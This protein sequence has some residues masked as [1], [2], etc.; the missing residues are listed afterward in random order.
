MSQFYIKMH[1]KLLESHLLNQWRFLHKELQTQGNNMKNIFSNHFRITSIGIFVILLLFF[2]SQRA[3][4]Q[5]QNMAFMHGADDNSGAGTGVSIWVSNNDGTFKLCKISDTGFDRDNVNTEVFGDQ[6]DAQTF[7]EDVTGDGIV[8]IVHVTEY[9]NRS[10]FVYAGN[11]RGGFAK[12]P[13]ATSNFQANTDGT[14]FAGLSGIEQGWIADADG[15]G[16]KDYVQAGNDNKIHVYKGNGDGTFVTTRITTTLTGANGYNASGITTDEVAFLRDVNGDGKADLVETNQGDNR[17]IRVWLATSAGNYATTPVT[18]TNFQQTGSSI[19]TGMGGNETSGLE[20]INGDGKL[21]FVHVNE[22]D[23][24]NDIFVFLGNG[25]GTFVTTYIRTVINN[26][27]GTSFQVIGD[28]A[29]EYGQFVD[30]TADGKIDFVTSHEAIGTNSG[31][32]V[33]IGNGDG[34]FQVAP[35]ST[36]FAGCGGGFQTGSDAT[37]TTKIVKAFATGVTITSNCRTT[38]ASATACGPG[39]V[40]TDLLLWLKAGDLSTAADGSSV[41]SWTDGTSWGTAAQLTTTSQPT[42]YKTNAAKLINFNESLS[43]DGGDELKTDHRLY[44][45]NS[46]FQLI[47][48]GLEE[49]TSTGQLRAPLGIGVDGNYPALDLQTD[50]VSPN[51]WN[52]WMSASSP[53]EWNGGS[54]VLLAK[55]PQVFSLGS[56][57][58]SSTV[59]YSA[60]NIISWVDGFKESTT[61]DAF[62]QSEIGNGA[63]I[64]SSGGEQWVGRI[65]ETIIYTRQLSDAEMQ[66]VDTYLGIKYGITVQHDYY[67]AAG[68]KIWDKTAN[69][70]YHFNVAG[71]GREDCQALNQK[72][73]KSATLTETLVISGSTAITA[74][75]TANTAA[76]TDH[77]FMVWG[78]NNLSAS[79]GVAYAPTSYSPPSGYYRMARV[80]KVQ[81]TGTVGVGDVTVAVPQG[82]HLLVS[83]DPTFASGVTEVALSDNGNG[84]WTASYNFTNGQYFT[85]GNE[86]P[87]P[88]CVAGGNIRVWLKADAGIT[89]A[90]GAVVTSWADQSLFNYDVNQPTAANQPTYY[91][92][93][94]SKLVNFNP[95]LDFDGVNDHLR[96]LTPLMPSTSPYTFMGVGLDEDA[97]T[98]YRALFSSEQFVD[99][100]ILY[101]QGGA[102][103]DNGWTPY[104]IGGLLSDRGTFGKGTKY[105]IA[106]GANGFWNGT[107]FTSNATTDIVQP[108][109]VGMSGNNAL[110]SILNPG[111][112][113]TNFFTWLDGYKDSPGNW[114]PTDEGNSTYQSY[115]FKAYGVGTDMDANGSAFEFWKGRIPELIAYDRQLTDAEMAKVNT[116]FGIKYGITLGQGNGAVGNNNNN[117]DYVRGDGTVIWSATAN[118]TYKFNIAGIGRDDCQGLLQKQSKSARP[119]EVVTISGGTGISAT[120]TANNAA[121]SDKSFLVWGSNNLSTSYAT[122]YAPTSFVPTGSYARMARV[123]K[124]Q[125]TGTVGAVTVSVPSG[126]HLLVST[127]PTMA[128]GVTEVA[129][130]TDANGNKVASYNFTSGQYFTFGS[131]FYAPGCVATGLQVW[132]KADAGTSSTTD[133]TALTQWDDQSSNGRNHTQT[134][135]SYQPKFKANGGFN[136]NPAVTFDG[137]DVLTTDAFASGKEAVHVFTMAKVGDSGWRALYG[138][139][140]DATH[141]QW[142]STKPSVW[143]FANQTPSTALSLDYGISSFILPKDGSQKTINWN[144]TVG[145]ISGI[146][147]YTY[148]ASKMGVGSDVT[149]DGLGLSENFL[150]DIQ[151]MI[152]YKTGTPTVNGG[153]MATTDINKIESYL[154]VKYGITLAHDYLAG[155]GTKVWD[156]TANATFHNNVAGIARE[157]CQRLNQKQSKSVNA[158]ATLTIAIDSTI[159][160]SNTANPGAFNANKSYL[161]VGDNNLTGSTS[162]T[163]GTACTPASVDK[164]TNKVWMF[165]ETGTVE[166]SKVSVDLAGYGFNANYPVYMQVSSDA[167]FTNVVANIPMKQ[168]GAFYE[169]NYDFT[170]TQYVRFVGNTTALANVCSG[171][172]TLNWNGIGNT[173]GF[174]NWGTKSKNYTIGDQQIQ[175]SVTDPSNVTY[176]TAWYPVNLANHL[177]IPRYDNQATA[178]ITTRIKLMDAAGTTAK[179]AQGVDFKITDID[180]YIGGKDVVNVYGKLNGVNVNPKLSLNKYTAINISGTQATG[181]ILPWDWSAWGTMYVTFDSP[182]DEIY[183]EY[184]KNNQY[185]FKVFN[186]IAIGN[187]NI[188][189]KQPVPE[190]IT[191]DNVYIFKEVSPNPAK[192]NEAFTYKFTIQNNNCNAQTVNLNDVLPS[193]VTWVDSTLATPLT[194]ASTNAY[195]GSATLNLTG[196]A[197]PTGTSYIYVSAKA[198]SAGTYNNQAS[199]TLNSH[200]YQSD[201]PSL[202]GSANPTPITINAVP[203]AN[204]TVSKSV[205]KS[206]V[207][208]N[209]VI[210][211]TF[212]IQ[213]NEATAVSTVF[214]DALDKQ[215]TY[216]A[217][218]L[219]TAALGSAQISAYAGEGSI[220]IRDLSIPA[221]GS[222]SFSIN[223]NVNATAYGDTVRNSYKLTPDMTSSFLQTTVKSNTVATK[224]AALSV[225]TPPAQTAS[226]GQA[227]SGNAA[228]EL[229]PS[230]GTSPYVYSNGSSDPACVA[231]VGA[232]ALP[233]TSNLTVNSSS[234]AYSYTA[235]SIPGT[236]YFCIKVCDSGTPTPNCTVTTYTLTVAGTGPV[237]AGTIACSST[238]MIPA[239]V[240]GSPSNHALYVTVNVTSNGTFSPVTV[241]GSGFTLSQSPYSISTTTTG[242]QT[243]VIPV[244]YDGTTLTNNL[245][246]TVGAAGTCAAD[247]TK[248]AK[249]VSKNVYS[250]DGCTAVIPGTLSK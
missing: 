250:L 31:I 172:K 53:A 61:L 204:I 141:V 91:S 213:N 149:S 73:S 41:G 221:N 100:F 239:P 136:F 51:G 50:G 9:N 14:V 165:V 72:Q 86:A 71:I 235:P 166:S 15:D 201:E 115:L 16:K 104:A 134:N 74:T 48:V 110:N 161:M 220:T 66:K 142:L 162:V 181:G 238:Q 106:G 225:T 245:Q 59:N 203:T 5:V 3:N 68:V 23:A 139:G 170:G 230:G 135:T 189:C 231:P 108:Q 123:W 209:G 127:D 20:D 126:M 227:K 247:M 138:F 133:G 179:P 40:N 113:R 70:A 79:F 124:V 159:S 4:A 212:N 62:Q 65:P 157:D 34:T 229:A 24:N 76:L 200:T 119:D 182:V 6:G 175:V 197:V 183:V 228:T 216:V 107:N 169:T 56:T 78:N 55:Q 187:L 249:V 32:F 214:E 171:N 234:G 173:G 111:P 2:S 140:R 37:E 193:G 144:G 54:A 18:T 121:F 168:N 36:L 198:S 58:S 131:E 180:G 81:E 97:G 109:I 87:A 202:A 96:N 99:H 39:G 242:V 10:I 205:D 152:V 130:T 80:W 208:Q 92:T 146:D 88:G 102:I 177:Y 98:G 101:K 185:S 237:A 137:S 49:R 244:H 17:S 82:K 89:A 118:S 196:I 224:I 33:Y 248:P 122:T 210:K 21:D 153:P 117:Y 151:E 44:C 11:G 194:I 174:W 46:Q 125:E 243:F 167:A 158:G 29:S 22:F 28:Y 195:G 105:S 57:N 222:I 156:K 13:T 155:D 103:S 77:S 52:P 116:Y 233:P 93:T 84:N 241:T 25:D 190:V 30:V 7:F 240:A 211:Y 176:L 148:N 160:T 75:N 188:T 19:F 128:T 215:A 145:N 64:G 246:F 8:D 164:A 12:T 67:S 35:V 83:T 192:T 95:T 132:L 27:S 47:T 112:A 191:P 236:Y 1:L 226:A 143:L 223:A 147:T 120:N 218:S 178:K 150:G 63:F 154:G 45:N 38:P 60:N 163:P 94:A 232:T 184:T 199:F 206:T 186:D 217:S 114:A 42:F 90:D 43:F 219:T 85:F 207:A 69:S 129:M 26:P